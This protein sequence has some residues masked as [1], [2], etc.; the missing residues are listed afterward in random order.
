MSEEISEH[1]VRLR[2][3]ATGWREVDGPELTEDDPYLDGLDEERAEALVRSN[4][5]VRHADVDDAREF[6][7]GS[8]KPPINPSEFTVDELEAEVSESDYSNTELDAIAAAEADGED[9]NT[10]LEAIDEARD[11]EE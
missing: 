3:D 10:A 6:Y 8:A 2:D 4:W 7:E 1:V 5:A 11:G 9:R